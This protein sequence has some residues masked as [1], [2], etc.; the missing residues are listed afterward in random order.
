MCNFVSAVD[1]Q[2]HKVIYP[3]IWTTEEEIYKVTVTYGNI[4]EYLLLTWVCN[5]RG[6]STVLSVFRVLDWILLRLKFQLLL[7]FLCFLKSCL[8]TPPS[9]VGVW[10]FGPSTY[11]QVLCYYCF[12]C[13][14]L[15]V[16]LLSASGCCQLDPRNSECFWS[17][18][19]S[20]LSSSLPRLNKRILCWFVIV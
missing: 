1:H 3:N 5:N 19:A 8:Q 9:V 17:I 20:T 16:H 15:A 13:W 2:P 7:L 11:I 18:S 12:F 4:F 10:D 6:K 14:I